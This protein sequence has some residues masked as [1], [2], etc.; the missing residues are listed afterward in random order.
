[1]EFCYAR[2]FWHE[3]DFFHHA[4]DWKTI[5]LLDALIG[6]EWYRNGKDMPRLT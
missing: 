2:Q 4:L 3:T 1:M 5:M 6:R